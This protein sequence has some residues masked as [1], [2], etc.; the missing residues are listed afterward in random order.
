MEETT[1]RSY[2]Y[3]QSHHLNQVTTTITLI[4]L[5]ICSDSTYYADAIDLTDSPIPS[6]SNQALLYSCVSRNSHLFVAWGTS[7]SA[8]RLRHIAAINLSTPEGITES[9]HIIS[10]L[11]SRR[12]A[13][14]T[15]MLNGKR[16]AQTPSETSSQISGEAPTQDAGMHHEA[17]RA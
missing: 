13:Y 3:R 10:L 15:E 11:T 17:T 1:Q 6:S 14:Y 9:A 5:R 12:H 8:L 4:Q 2:C 16:R 7:C